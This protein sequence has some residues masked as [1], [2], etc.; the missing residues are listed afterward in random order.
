MFAVDHEGI[1]PDL[2]CLGKGITGGYLPPAAT[3]ATE[4]IFNAFMAP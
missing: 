3:L 4:E 1:E 2:L